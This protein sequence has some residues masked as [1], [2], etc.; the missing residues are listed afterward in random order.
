VM[1]TLC[2][3]WQYGD[4]IRLLTAIQRS[5]G[6]RALRSGRHHLSNTIGG[7]HYRCVI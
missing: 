2:S 5:S 6:K 3:Q 4:Q 7:R 1:L